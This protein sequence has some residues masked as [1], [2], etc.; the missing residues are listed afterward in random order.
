LFQSL[1]GERG[2]VPGGDDPL[3]RLWEQASAAQLSGILL[4]PGEPALG[5][6]DGQMSPLPGLVASD[7]ITMAIAALGASVG[8]LGAQRRESPSGPFIVSLLQ[9]A[10]G[11]AL[12]LKGVPPSMDWTAA[13]LPEDWL[14]EAAA[15]R[16]ASSGWARRRRRAAA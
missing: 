15:R 14:E 5:L 8:T 12:F 3:A 9:E 7:T 2:G 11:E 10:G 16:A 6:K 4:R 13:G 1:R